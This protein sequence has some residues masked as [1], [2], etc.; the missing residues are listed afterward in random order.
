VITGVSVCVLGGGGRGRCN[1]ALHED[2]QQGSC[3]QGTIC[4]W[5]QGGGSGMSPEHGR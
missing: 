2:W 1:S 4:G 5:V 3:N